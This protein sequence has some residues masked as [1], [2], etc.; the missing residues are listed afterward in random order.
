MSD[1]SGDPEKGGAEELSK[2]RTAVHR[3]GTNVS[4]HDVPVEQ[5]RPDIAA[6]IRSAIATVGRDQRVLVAACGPDKLMKVVRNTTAECIAVDG[7][8]VE[9]HCEQFGW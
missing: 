1:G 2:V 6:L 9:L 7:P 5:G 3:T 4:V 8:A